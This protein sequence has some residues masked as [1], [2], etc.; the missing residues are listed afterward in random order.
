M[1]YALEE[2]TGRM[3]WMV[4]IAADFRI[5]YTHAA[6]RDTHYSINEDAGSTAC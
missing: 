5:G 1:V 4:P 6:G 3:I 2:V